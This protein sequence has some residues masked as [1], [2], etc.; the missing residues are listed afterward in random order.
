MPLVPQGTGKDKEGN[1]IAYGGY[2]VQLET[3][4]ECDGVYAN[5][6]EHDK[7]PWHVQHKH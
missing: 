2:V 1:E 7:A 6:T 3:C 5:R 4:S